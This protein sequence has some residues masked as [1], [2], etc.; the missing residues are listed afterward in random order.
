VE[1]YREGYQLSCVGYTGAGFS[2][3]GGYA[4]GGSDLC[5]GSG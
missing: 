1:F 3:A 5:S 2:T 4:A